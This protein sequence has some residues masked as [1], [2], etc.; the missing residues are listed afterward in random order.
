MNAIN[1]MCSDSIMKRQIFQNTINI[2]SMMMTNNEEEIFYSDDELSDN[3]LYQQVKYIF[4][5]E[6]K[7]L[8]SF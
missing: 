5:I 1:Q 3:D 8:V 4:I 2:N 6:T 7:R